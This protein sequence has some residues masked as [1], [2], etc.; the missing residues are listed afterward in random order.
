[1]ISIIAA[2]G[3]NNELGLNNDLLWHLKGD[4]NFFRTLTSGKI[5]V[6]GRKCFESLPG[7]LPNRENVIVTRNSDY[8][9]AGAKIFH[10]IKDVINYIENSDND[11]FIIGGAKIYEEFLPIVENLY[12]TEIDDVKEADVFFPDFNKDNYDK[13]ILDVNEEDGVKYTFSLYRK[14]V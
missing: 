7:I 9:V 12:L 5:V 1:M 8:L 10:D 3:R 4:M 14:K 2:I 11:V 6:M 13:E